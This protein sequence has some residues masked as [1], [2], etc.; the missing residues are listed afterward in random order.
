MYMEADIS[1]DI[2]YSFRSERFAVFR[3]AGEVLRCERLFFVGC[4]AIV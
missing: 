2:F 4:C 3:P 1:Q